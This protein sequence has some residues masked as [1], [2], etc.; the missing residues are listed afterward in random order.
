METKT[1]LS[2]AVTNPGAASDVFTIYCHIH[3]ESGRRYIGQTKKTWRKRWNQHVYTALGEKNGWSHFANAIRKY[4][5]NAFTHEV[6]EI[7]HNLESANASEKKWI[8]HFETTDPKK[9]FNFKSGGDHRPHQITN[10]WDRPEFRSKG[11]ANLTKTNASLTPQ[12][13]SQISKQLW[14]DPQF[15]LKVSLTQRGKKLSPEHIAK[16]AASNTGKKRSLEHRSQISE[17]SKVIASN[18]EYRA[19]ISERMKGVIFTDEHRNNISI[20][21][22]GR[23]LS[24]ETRKK[25]GLSALI[26]AAKRK[27]DGRFIVLSIESRAKISASAKASNARRRVLAL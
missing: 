10:P 20:G 2:E 19:R 8:A 14:Q 1:E 12:K 25:I 26:S 5:K 3:T 21:Q 4:G 6:L 16:S 7:C 23:I 11:L 13:R 15:R 24:A 9:G 17:R 27:A 18:P 22:R